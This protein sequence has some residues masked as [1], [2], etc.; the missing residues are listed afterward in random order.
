VSGHHSNR[1]GTVLSRIGKAAN[2]PSRSAHVRRAF[3]RLG[4]AIVVALIAR[5][6]AMAQKDLRFNKSADNLMAVLRESIGVNKP[7]EVLIPGEKGRTILPNGR[8]VVVDFA[9]FEFIGDM[10]IRFVFD[11]PQ[12]MLIATAHDLA[13]LNLSPDEAIQVAVANIKRVYGAPIVKPWV[14]GL[15]QVQGK[16]SDLDSSYFLD[17]DFWRELIREHP[18]GL[19]V[20]VPKRGGLVFTPVTETDVV[21]HLRKNVAYLYSTSEKMRI[22][23]ALYL[24]KDDHWTVFQSPLTQ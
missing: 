7:D 8:E 21:E 4:L 23:S 3:V 15:M 22:S 14:G 10:H 5:E 16:S 24:F 17:R 19:V 9:Y 1:G 6:G 13:Q 2:T 12:S 18:E 20:A 11:G